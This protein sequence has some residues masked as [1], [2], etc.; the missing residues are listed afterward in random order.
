[1]CGITGFL[2]YKH[3]L[4][5]EAIYPMIRSLSHRGPDYVGV[6]HDNSIPLSVGHARLSIIDT[7]AG[8]NQPML[9]HNERYVI[10]FNGE[11]YNHLVL[12]KELQSEF[13]QI[14]WNSRS[15]TETLLESIS[16]WGLELALA[17]SSGMFAFALWDIEQ[18]KLYLGRDRIGEKPL[19]YGVHDDVLL[20]GSELKALKQHE[21]FSN[22][23]SFLGLSHYLQYSYIPSPQSIYEFYN[24]VPPGSVV[25]FSQ[26][27]A[28][29]EIKFYWNLTEI[30]LENKGKKF[31]LTSEE[32]VDKLEDLLRKSVQEQRISDVPIGAFLSGGID[33]SAVV[34]IFQSLSD[35]PIST[36]SIGFA[37]EE[38][39]EAGFAKEIAHYLG[40]VHTELF[41]SERE[42]SSMLIELPHIYCEPFADVSQIPTFFVSK[43]ARTKVTVSMSGDGGDEL[44]GGYTRYTQAERLWSIYGLVPYSF[45]RTCAAP[46]K[47]IFPDG[48][49]LSEVIS[50]S[51]EHSGKNRLSQKIRNNLE[52]FESKDF[53]SLYNRLVSTWPANLMSFRYPNASSPILRHDQLLNNLGGNSKLLSVID[54]FTY[55]PDD[56]LCKLDRAAMRNSLESRAPFLN[57]DLVEFA[58]SIPKDIN[59]KNGIAK[60]PL[61]QVLYKY[62]PLSF[63]NR[64]KRGFGIPIDKWLRFGLKTWAESLIYDDTLSKDFPFDEELILKIWNQHQNYQANHGYK[65][66]NILMLKAW[67]IENKISLS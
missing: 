35:R 30:A 41:L 17:K 23:L 56:V 10:V 8:G 42:I 52:Y 24:K 19:Y 48:F 67:L 44:F 29:P 59:N 11:I 36:F 53:L 20:F 46:F 3:K 33:S 45:R 57:K 2:S 28:K 5:R 55:L 4:D 7:S 16:N 65:I 61:K 1:M 32:T 51:S 37:E 58:L 38:Y 14:N 27:L 40:T 47:W 34:S 49:R 63:T 31:N 60:W 43:L 50:A 62:L 9:S 66:W 26:D 22:K 25:V 54:M 6:W 12:R 39:N 64:P 18:K 21:M 13:G 15:D